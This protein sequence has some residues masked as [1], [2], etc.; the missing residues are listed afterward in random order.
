MAWPPSQAY[1]TAATSSA[2]GMS[3]GMPALTTTIVR[4]L[5]AATRRTSSS[6]R[7]VSA[8]PVRSNP[9]LSAAGADITMTMAA[10]APHAACSACSADA[11]SASSSGAGTTPS[12]MDT[13]PGAPPDGN[14][15]T[16]I[17]AS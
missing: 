5:T 13:G 4:S 9:S 2:H 1:P 3:T 15:A 14:R 7:P 11:S 10:S 16:S 17:S 8:S 12:R 6:W